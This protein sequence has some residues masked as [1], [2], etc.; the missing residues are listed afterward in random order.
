MLGAIERATSLAPAST[1]KKS[2]RLYQCVAGGA[3]ECGGNRIGP[4]RRNGVTHQPIMTA[5]PLIKQVVRR[6][7]T[8]CAE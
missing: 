1:V 6:R 5:R 4:L 7:V 2:R 8:I 3:R